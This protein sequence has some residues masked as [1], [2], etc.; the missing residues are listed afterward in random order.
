MPRLPS[1]LLASI[2]RNQLTKT[3]TAPPEEHPSADATRPNTLETLQQMGKSRAEQQVGMLRTSILFRLLRLLPT[4]M[5]M[6]LPFVREDIKRLWQSRQPVIDAPP[7][8]LASTDDQIIRPETPQSP[9]SRYRC[10]EHPLACSHL[11]QPS[12]TETIDTNRCQQCDFPSLLA[13]DAE[14]RGQRGRY[15]VGEF[16]GQRGRG[17]LYKAQDLTRRQ[18]VI[19]REYLLPEKHFNP[20]EQRLIHETFATIAGLKLADG[21]EQDFRLVEPWDIIGDRQASERCYLITVDGIDTYPTLR[22]VLT[23]QGAFT[24]Q[25]VR[26]IL[27]QILQ[28]LESL[29]GQKYALQ[30]GQIQTG[31]VHGNITLDSL[32]MQPEAATYYETP[33][34][35]VFLRDLGLWESLFVPPPA[36][37]KV[38]Q[39]MDD[40]NAVGTVGFYLL[41]GKWIDIY[42]RALKPQNPHLW[43]GQDPPLEAYL[44]QLLGLEDVPFDSAE[45]ARQSL[46]RLPT[47]PVDSTAIPV[48]SL[49]E[50]SPSHRFPRWLIWLLLGGLGLLA[51][52]SLFSWWW[53]RRR[54]V[55]KAVLPLCCM[56]EVPAIPP[57]EFTYTAS[58]SWHSLWTSQNLVSADQSLEQIVETIEPALDLQLHLTASSQTAIE[59]VEQGK[60]A[61]AVTP[62]TAER[63]LLAEPIAYDGLAVFVAFSYVERARGLPHHLQ[64]QISLT[65][66]RQLY[67]GEILNWQELGGPDLPVK[68]YL[69]EQPALIQ[70]FEER[71]L[72][73]PAAIA[74][75]RRQWGLESTTVSGTVTQGFTAS[76]LINGETLPTL[77]ILRSV[78]QDFENQPQIGSIGFA[79]LSQVYGQCSVYP[80]A[81]ASDSSTAI[82]PLA[83]PDQSP[84]TPADDLCGD[85]GNYKPQQDLFA[86]QTYPLA[87]P[88]AVH[89]QVD[90]SRTPVAP[91]FIQM[92]TTDEGQQLLSKT[93]LVPLRPLQIQSSLVKP[94]P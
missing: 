50:E 60:A 19:L 73:T 49:A 52:G 32:V 70:L 83:Y 78:L 62:L 89:H 65:Q 71:V 85:K 69:P 76:D 63:S 10:T 53:L 35:L 64:G 3:T 51:T 88:I 56:A 87:Y 74:T 1:R 68:L 43:P 41:R 82:Q 31:L 80:L 45:T 6:V 28:T 38:S 75:F 81:I 27:N 77:D 94:A 5:L 24:S 86:N 13:I 67:T 37:A 47:P 59:Q 55:S 22:T 90:N 34:L 11:V 36:P 8:A 26:Q 4:P 44:K 54:P 29:H 48:P 9:Y 72:Q 84:L 79:N 92:M 12:T 21:R 57:G 33:Q 39:V 18:P 7:K 25:Q 42:G 91:S 16:L 30:T 93:G 66:L 17:R 14:I 2:S 40:L 46:L 61:F 58:N 20:T 23:Q 15:R